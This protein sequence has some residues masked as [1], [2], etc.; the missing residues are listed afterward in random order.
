M[1]SLLTVRK[2]EGAKHKQELRNGF[3]LEQEVL[4]TQQ[5]ESDVDEDHLGVACKDATGQ[6]EPEL[7]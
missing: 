5:R 2:M 1:S 6:E 3:H 7:G 4:H